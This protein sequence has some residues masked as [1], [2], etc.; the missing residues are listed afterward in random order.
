[1]AATINPEQLKD[2]IWRLHNLYYIVDKDAKKV[3]FQ[4]NR[5]QLDF[6]QNMHSR[7][8]ILK[9]RRLGF[10]TVCCLAYLDDCLFKPNITAALIAHKLPDAQKIFSSKVKFPY[11]NLAPELK[12][13]IPVKRETTDEL[14]FKNNSEISVTT[15]ARSGT[16]SWLHISE[17]GKICS[18]YPDKAQEIRTGS[19]PAA[20]R[21]VITIESTAEGE[22]GDFYE[23]TTNAQNL[24]R[25]GAV[26]TRKDFKFFFYPWWGDPGSSMPRSNI[27]ISDKDE[28][29]FERIGNDIKAD[30]LLSKG[31]TGFTREQK[32]WWVTEEFTQGGDMKREYPATP[33]EAFEQALDGA[34]FADHLAFAYKHDHIGS[35]PFDS[36]YPVNT[37]WDL[38]RSHGNATA[39]WLEQ[40]IDNLPRFVGY[41]EKEGEWID[42]HLRNLREWGNERG[43]TWGKHYMPHDGDVEP[44]WLP[45]GTLALMGKLGFT[46]AIV[47]RAANKWESIQVARRRFPQ[48]RFDADGCKVGLSRLKRYRKEWDDRRGVW[49]DHPYHGPESNGADAFRTFAESG[50]MPAPA[51]R[52][53]ASDAHKRRFY[54]RETSGSWLTQ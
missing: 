11:D 17:Y 30:P 10:T 20:E 23:N 22:G 5:A 37:F 52:L 45:E 1:M 33:T 48:C 8:V 50:H 21:G 39:V 4:P 26:L 2:P 44:V 42:Q 40:D 28:E 41:Y 14:V 13:R 16:L 7:N 36:R 38:G 27:P 51:V 29:Y 54:D 9:A 49:R 19:F 12:E 24:A 34:I 15:S 35:F 18:Q 6:I 43:V 31:F 46:P 47:T 3:L 25:T 53:D 32:N